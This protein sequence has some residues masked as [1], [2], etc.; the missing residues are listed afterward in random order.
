M[1]CPGMQWLGTKEQSTKEQRW[2]LL[3]VPRNSKDIFDGGDVRLGYNRSLVLAR[4][5]HN[6]AC[7][8]VPAFRSVASACLAFN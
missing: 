2:G 6:D 3:I 5:A 4:R 7:A 1:K 8:P